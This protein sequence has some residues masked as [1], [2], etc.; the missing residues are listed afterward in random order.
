MFFV[1]IKNDYVLGDK[2]SESSTCECKT[3]PTRKT[4]II[5]YLTFADLPIFP[6]N[7]KSTHLC[8]SCGCVYSPIP[9]INSNDW[10][11]NKFN[12]AS[13]FSGWLIILLA[14]YIVGNF[15]AEINP[16]DTGF[17]HEPRV[18]DLVFINYHLM[19]RKDR[20]FSHPY[21]IAKITGLDAENNEVNATL[22]KWSNSTESGVIKDYLSQQDKYDSNFSFPITFDSSAL[23]NK[24]LVF[25]MRRRNFD[26]E[27]NSLQKRLKFTD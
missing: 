1:N 18:G 26:G 21:I 19:S 11:N 15:I 3:Q 22:L 10:R 13:K 5:R 14:M 27:F 8:T 16:D 25:G 12:L 2:Y 24:S 9:K 4:L 17:R 23:D 7:F 20:Y 6:I